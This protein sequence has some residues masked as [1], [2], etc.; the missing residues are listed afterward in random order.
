[1]AESTLYKNEEIILLKRN[2]EQI[3]RL[4]VAYMQNYFY[5][6][7]INFMIVVGFGVGRGQTPLSAIIEVRNAF[8][9][10][11]CLQ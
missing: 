2:M 4:L 8:M 5:P 10:Q 7:E 3:C 6:H 9:S 1:M 11:A